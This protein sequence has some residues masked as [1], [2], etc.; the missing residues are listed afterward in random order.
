[1]RRAREALESCA[2]MA[3]RQ[4]ALLHV[5]V[6][7][8]GA[9][10]KLLAAAPGLGWSDSEHPG[11]LLFPLFQK[12][13]GGTPAQRPFRG[14][15]MD[16]DELERMSAD[17]D[18]TRI[19]TPEVDDILEVAGI[20]GP[21]DVGARAVVLK[22]MRRAAKKR[23]A[24]VTEHKRRRYY[25]HAAQLVAACAA[26][27]INGQL[28]LDLDEIEDQKGEADVPIAFTPRTGK[29]TLLQMDGS[30]TRTEF[31]SALKLSIDGCTRV[32]ALQRAALKNFYGAVEP[33]EGDEE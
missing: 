9:A 13:L 32:H 7:D 27:K 28:V 18:E 23:V 3:H 33:E 1:M 30:L 12:L 26:G 19:A 14:R 31:E 15:R 29:I 11:Q 24:G 21:S 20:K 5:I 22:A 4:R 8:L 17:G 10:A 16:T 2:K 25:G 6:G